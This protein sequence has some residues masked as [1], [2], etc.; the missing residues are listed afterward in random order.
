M[1]GQRPLER[2]FSGGE[3]HEGGCHRAATSVEP[4]VEVGETQDTLKLFAG[5]RDGPGS[6]G[7]DLG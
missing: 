6:D 5:V 1:G 2:H 7:G 3:G 4:P